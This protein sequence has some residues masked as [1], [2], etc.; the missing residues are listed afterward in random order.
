MHGVVIQGGKLMVDA[1]GYIFWNGK[2]ADSW[3]YQPSEEYFN[4]LNSFNIGMM[5]WVNSYST[6]PL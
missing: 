2:Y 4:N 1:G 5:Q 6:E 3:L